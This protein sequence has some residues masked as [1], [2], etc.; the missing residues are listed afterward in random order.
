MITYNH[1]HYRL[2]IKLYTK[3]LLFNL[4]GFI[5]Y[6]AVGSTQIAFY[7]SILKIIVNFEKIFSTY[8]VYMQE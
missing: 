4:F 1:A 3:M 6:A 5:F 7:R 2:I 8:F